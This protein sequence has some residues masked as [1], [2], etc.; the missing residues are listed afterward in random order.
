MRLTYHPEAE[1]EIVQAA[2]YY[3]KQVKGLGSRF[4]GD[5]EATIARI[6]EAP[7]RW[8]LVEA[9]VRR[10][11]LRRFPY[12][13]YYRVLPSGVRILVV[14]HHRR[15]PDYWRERISE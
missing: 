11:S 10:C 2:G 6:V 4:L 8:P 3:E 9:D 14:K 15:H 12:A 13:V 1:A 7:L 5:L